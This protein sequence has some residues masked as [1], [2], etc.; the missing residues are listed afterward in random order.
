MFSLKKKK[1]KPI[2]LFQG[3]KKER[4]ATPESGVSDS[5]EAKLVS[6]FWIWNGSRGNR[7]HFGRGLLDNG[8]WCQ[9]PQTNSPWKAS[10]PRSQGYHRDT[11]RGNEV[12]PLSLSTSHFPPA[13]IWVHSNIIWKCL[14]HLD[15][16]AVSVQET[17]DQFQKPNWVPQLPARLKT[18]PV[19]QWNAE[20]KG[21]CNLSTKFMVVISRIFSPK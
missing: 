1:H 15:P 8:L 9:G 18:L 2:G 21:R 12:L 17:L 4:K 19:L 7:L 11:Q 14:I 20:T 3:E 16:M 5:G 13:Y 10:G 6:T